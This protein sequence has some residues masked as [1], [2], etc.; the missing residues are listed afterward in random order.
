MKYSQGHI[1]EGLCPALIFSH[2]FNLNKELYVYSWIWPLIIM[3]SSLDLSWILE[4]QI[5]IICLLLIV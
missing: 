3:V 5:T 1:E 2:P 4:D